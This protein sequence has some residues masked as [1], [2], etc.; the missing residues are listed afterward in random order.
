MSTEKQLY[1]PIPPH[2]YDLVLGQ[3]KL[4][5]AI[6]KYISGDI[7]LLHNK[8][9]KWENELGE[10]FTDDIF[11]YAKMHTEVY[12]I[13]NIAKFRSFQ[14]RLLQRSLI[15]NIQLSLWGLH[16]TDLCSFC[17]QYKETVLH[18]MFECDIVRELW[19]SVK[20]YLI[21][22]FENLS[23]VW[24][25][26]AI[27][28]NRIFLGKQ[29]HASNFICLLTKQFIYKQRCLNSSLAFPIL[30]AY[31]QKVENIEKY[32]AKKNGKSQIHMRKW[33]GI[34]ENVENEN[35]Q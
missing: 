5:S 2:N 8:L 26:S 18:I 6:Y 34:L 19:N 15:T 29:N 17:H 28:K 11:A 1:S 3:K 24:T 25:A 32:I 7:S 14:Y 30:K 21:E 33:G 16:H 4:S 10:D 27:V 23:L 12:R 9:V 22:R 35:F 13:T 31:I 20:K